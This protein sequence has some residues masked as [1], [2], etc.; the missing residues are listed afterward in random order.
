MCGHAGR[1]AALAS[2]LLVF[3][4]LEDACFNNSLEVVLESRT[5]TAG[6]LISKVDLDGCQQGTLQI[7][8]S[9]ARFV[10]KSGVLYAVSGFNATADQ[11]T[12]DIYLED[13]VTQDPSK[14]HVRLLFAAK[15]KEQGRKRRAVLLHRQKRRWQPMPFKLTENSIGPFPKYVQ[16]I[17]SDDEQGHTISYH[18][19]GQGV[20]KHP[21]NLF[22][23]ESDTGRIFVSRPVDREEFPSFKLF[24]KAIR[25]GGI[26]HERLLDL[27]IK[28]MDVNDNVPMFTEKEFVVNFPECSAAGTSVTTLIATDKDEPNT[29]NTLLVY[30]ILSQEPSSRFGSFFSID[31]KTGEIKTNSDKLNREEQNTYTLEVEVQDLDGKSYGLSSRGKVVIHLTDMNDH[32]PTFKESRYTI[33]VKET[34][35]NIMVL[36]M[37]VE[38]KDIAG[39]NASRAVF[40]IVKGN[41]NGNF[42]VSTDPKTNEGLLYVVKP[43]DAETTRLLQLDVAV[44]NEAPL[45]GKASQQQVAKVTV[46]VLDVD[47]GPE[48]VPSVK[49]LWTE[50]NVALRTTLGSFTARDPETQ[51]SDNIRYRKL[52][53]PADWVSIDPNTGQIQTAAILDRE[54]MYVKHNKYNV[55]VLAMEDKDHSRS[56][57][58]TVVINLHDVNDNSPVISNTNLYI[59]ENGD[60]HFVNISAEDLDASPNAAPFTFL[61][62]NDPLEIKKK[63]EIFDNAGSYAFMKP[64]GSLIPGHYKVPI[65]IQDQQH[66]ET[67]DTLKIVIC[68][69]PNKLNCAGRLASKKAVLGG[70]G[71][72]V[73][74]LAALCL[75]CL[76]LAAFALYCGGD[77][78]IKAPL[79]SQGQYHQT[80]IVSNEEGGGQQDMNLS[81]LDVPV[82]HGENMRQMHGTLGM[83]TGSGVKQTFSSFRG[84][85][86][87]V[88]MGQQMVDGS[89]GA[90]YDQNGTLIVDRTLYVDGGTIVDDDYT[91]GRRKSHGLMELLRSQV[92]RVYEDEQDDQEMPF[93]YVH[94]Y[95]HD[96]ENSVQ[97]SVGYDSDMMDPSRVDYMNGVG[98]KFGTLTNISL[99]K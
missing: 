64:K 84:A 46:N 12:F 49:H 20:D 29:I 87:E 96:G 76:L 70:L 14:I 27:T 2:L 45:I 26:M 9:D 17:R 94:G 50:E 90:F 38:D 42:N 53:D 65:I 95:P 25:K 86:T 24:G 7:G 28:V 11:I 33:D 44:E 23:V 35:S 62:P 54:S 56:C 82:N 57:T 97:G 77:R 37:P 98:T 92:D 80:L 43:L 60:H 69:C 83:G 55:T 59:C 63:W 15:L 48:F 47:E 31:G 81:S 99:K 21:A 36:R 1:I 52:T 67:K 41:E 13:S 40:K 61:L 74:F 30:R 88:D 39:T 5:I 79:G 89:S 75:L 72:L 8:S 71:I 66:H 6:Q 16:T 10:M 68:E 78:K 51:S 4:R 93:E 32:P 91:M 85:G 58:G 34:E 3:A 73:M 19:S 18:I 22:S